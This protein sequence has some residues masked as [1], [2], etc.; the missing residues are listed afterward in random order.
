[1][2]KKANINLKNNLKKNGNAE[3]KKFFLG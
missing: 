1:V 3:L 2:S